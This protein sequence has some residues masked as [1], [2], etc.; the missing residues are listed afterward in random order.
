MRSIQRTPVSPLRLP[1]DRC[2][3]V[4]LSSCW[5]FS[6]IK[7][8]FNHGNW[9][10]CAGFLWYSYPSL[11]ICYIFPRGHSE[12]MFCFFSLSFLRSYYRSSRAS[13][14]CYCWLLWPIKRFD[15]LNLHWCHEKGAPSSFAQEHPLQNQTFGQFTT[16]RF[17][18]SK[19]SESKRGPMLAT[20]SIVA[21]GPQ[22]INSNKHI[23]PQNRHNPS[24]IWI[25][26]KRH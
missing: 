5:P 11:Q 21:V 23:M 16:I 6:S 20:Y 15:D 3:S 13:V 17:C 14:V 26:E 4:D 24:F 10:S 19:S 2:F 25:F 1:G 22:Q 18:R 12:M 8:M 7:L 9:D